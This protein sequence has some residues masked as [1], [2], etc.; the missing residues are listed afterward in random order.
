MRNFIH[1]TLVKYSYLVFAVRHEERS[2]RVCSYHEM[3][4][5]TPPIFSWVVVMVEVAVVVVVGMG[6]V[7]GR[8]VVGS[9]D[10]GREQGWVQ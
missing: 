2:Y 10:G 6:T 7:A 8:G 1:V 3:L 4:F 5:W 9:D